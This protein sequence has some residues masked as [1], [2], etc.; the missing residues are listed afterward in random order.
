[1]TKQIN[2]SDTATD[3]CYRLPD[4]DDIFIE[5]LMKHYRGNCIA[6]QAEKYLES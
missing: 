3:Y 2:M 4:Q 5:E 6:R 1:M